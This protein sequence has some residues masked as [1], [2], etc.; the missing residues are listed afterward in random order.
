VKVVRNIAIILVLA[1]IVDLVPG[2]GNGAEAITVTIG[3]LFLAMIAYTA[4]RVFLQNRY[5][6][7]TLDHRHQATLVIA[8][9]AIVLMIAAADE[10]TRTGLGLIVWLGVLAAS[11]WAMVLV[12]Q[13]S[14][15]Y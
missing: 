1:L 12:Y 10:L 13:E 8:V 4:Y 3:M 2:G 14:K 7:L 15:S 6:Y 11:I 5:A 9:G